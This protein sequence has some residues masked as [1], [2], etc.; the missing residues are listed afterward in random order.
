M[1]NN[2]QK[3][4]VIEIENLD[5][6]IN[7]DFK[8]NQRTNLNFRSVLGADKQSQDNSTMMEMES[9]FMADD[10]SKNKE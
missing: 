10:H 1:I 9:H 4:S 3:L 5:K 8:S 7:K 6:L 2:Q